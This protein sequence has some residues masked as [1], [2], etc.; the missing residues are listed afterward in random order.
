MAVYDNR[1][2]GTSSGM[3][4]YNEPSVAQ[5][6]SF[7]DPIPLEFLQQN[8]QQHQQKYDVGYGQALAAKDMYAGVE[9]GKSDIMNKNNIVTEFTNNMDKIV[10]EKYGGDW[11]RASK[12]V[13]RMVTNVRQNPFWDTAKILRE[14]QEEAR[15]LKTQYGSEALVFDDLS[16][17]GSI[18]PE[19]GKII[20]PDKLQYDIRK[21]GDWAG[22]I[23]DILSRIKPD[24][25]VWGLSE[26]QFGY[27]KSGTTTQLT[28]DTI[29]K[30]AKDEN[31]QRAILSANPDMAEAFNKLPEE[32]EKWFGDNYSTISS[33]VEGLIRGRGK[34]MVFRQQDDQ[35]HRNIIG[36]EERAKKPTVEPVE[37]AFGPERESAAI[38]TGYG[39]SD[40][41]RRQIGRSIFSDTG[42]FQD[43][44][45]EA[46]EP[47]YSQVSKVNPSGLGLTA[48][49][50][51]AKADEMYKENMA[52]YR[53]RWEE[54]QESPEG[55]A[56]TTQEK[57]AKEIV[58]SFRKLNPNDAEGKS[59]R[60]V[61]DMFL[62]DRE[63][64]YKKAIHLTVPVMNTSILKGIGEATSSALN[65]TEFYF[66]DGTLASR[67][68]NGKKGIG[69][70]TGL[71]YVAFQEMLKDGKLAI[72]YNQTKG[73]LYVEIHV[74]DKGK[75][76]IKYSADGSINWTET[77]SSDKKK[78]YFSPDQMLKGIATT[79]PQLD[80]IIK[81]KKSADEIPSEITRI[82]PTIEYD[83]TKVDYSG[84]VNTQDVF[85]MKDVDGNDE[86]YSL[87]DIRSY[88]TDYVNQHLVEKYKIQTK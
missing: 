81:D 13:A 40:R 30:L 53:K 19:T 77:K 64:K 43:V 27:L 59:D 2:G 46:L 1:R 12:E 10:Q 42:T 5:Y 24:K 73:S 70:E 18:D 84:D 49:A 88:M 69:E 86:W 3:Y 9:V 51:K 33:A 37:S 71:P 76:A 20:T 25:N 79:L 58:G 83:K 54:Y 44:S 14:R 65:D 68:W 74:I 45:W 63:N 75:N 15:K 23:D 50:S 67:D 36:E 66:D 21:R 56:R 7:F 72:G 87:D 60:E 28:N 38:L 85:R 39:T 61:Y 8:L 6:Q 57:Q 55:K 82:F 26:D 11:G 52:T 32:R 48:E 35:F 47:Y 31:I 22:S 78:V 4:R 16:G 17:R 62:N 29:E 41:E 34:P 80:R